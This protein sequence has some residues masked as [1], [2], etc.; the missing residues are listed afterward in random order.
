MYVHVN[1]IIT[2]RIIDSFFRAEIMTRSLTIF[3]KKTEKQVKV[4]DEVPK[5]C[6]TKLLR[7]LYIYYSDIIYKGFS[8][9]SNA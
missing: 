5:F 2:T 6:G 3:K 9:L 4:L 1:I 7:I 8:L